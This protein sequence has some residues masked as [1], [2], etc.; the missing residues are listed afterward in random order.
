MRTKFA[1]LAVVMGVG[2]MLVSSSAHATPIT[3]TLTFNLTGFVDI[4]GANIPPP[5]TDISG[6]IIVHYDPTLSYDNDTTD[7]TVSY[8]NGVTV[9]SPLGF[10]YHNGFLE[11]GGTQNDS[12]EVY[13]NTNDLVVAFDVTNPNSPFFPSCA[14]P[15]YT[16]GIYTGSSAVDAAGY[17]VAGSD[18]GWFY[19]AQSTVTPTPPVTTPPSVTPEPSSL[20]LMATGLGAMVQV[21]RRRSFKGM[22]NLS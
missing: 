17:T 16:C 12:D 15:G 9:S 2:G 10:T 19:G 20:L 7:L 4:S 18:T 5:D 22:F 11:F 8:L 6:S 14:V 13:S 1:A 3:E 21:A